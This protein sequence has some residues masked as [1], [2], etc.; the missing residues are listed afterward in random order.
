VTSILYP[1]TPVLQ[2]SIVC[3]IIK[4]ILASASENDARSGKEIDHIAVY[5]LQRD[6]KVVD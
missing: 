5:Q 1:N 3:T 4:V 2:Y 6:K